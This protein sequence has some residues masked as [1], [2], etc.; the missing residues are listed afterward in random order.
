MTYGWHLIWFFK[1]EDT[2]SENLIILVLLHCVFTIPDLRL[3]RNAST[4]YSFVGFFAF[5]SS[6]HTWPG[7][8]NHLQTSV[9]ETPRA[10]NTLYPTTISLDTFDIEHHSSSTR[11][12]AATWSELEM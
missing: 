3:E 8:D 4:P 1:P 6:Q 10:C 11:I 2:K 5:S 12:L 9:E 7:Q